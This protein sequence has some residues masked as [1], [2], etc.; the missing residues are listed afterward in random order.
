VAPDIDATEHGDKHG[1]T[2]LQY[3]PPAIQRFHVEGAD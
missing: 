1:H 3:I 2:A